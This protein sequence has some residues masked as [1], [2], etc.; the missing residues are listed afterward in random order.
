MQIMFNAT[1]NSVNGRPGGSAIEGSACTV[2]VWDFSHS[3][4]SCVQN[5]EKEFSIRR[6][7]HKLKKDNARYYIGAKISYN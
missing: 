6:K 2:A 4:S 5:G 7:Q 1:Q 3:Y